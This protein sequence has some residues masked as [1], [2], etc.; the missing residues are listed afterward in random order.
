MQ[1]LL[2]C[3]WWH[4]LFGAGRYVICHMSYVMCHMSCVICYMSY[5][6]C[7][8]LCVICYMLYVIFYMLYVICYML[9]VI[10]YMLYVICYM[11]YV[12]KFRGRVHYSSQVLQ[13]NIITVQHYN[14][15]TVACELPLC[16]HPTLLHPHS[17]PTLYTHTLHP[18]TIWEY[19]NIGTSTSKHGNMGTWEHDKRGTWEPGNLGP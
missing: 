5:V 16:V 2:I 8:M 15:T 11:L 13:Y 19:G 9:Y 3:G 18:L 14:S 1:L 12:V 7:Y 10:C 17:T 4:W 6:M